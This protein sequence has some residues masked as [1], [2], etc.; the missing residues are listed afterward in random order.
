MSRSI[1]SM[2]GMFLGVAQKP[3]KVLDQI[4]FCGVSVS[5]VFER[6]HLFYGE[7]G[8]KSGAG[9]AVYHG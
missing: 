4:G 7:R 5:I 9:W 1:A 8:N 6:L 3:K 2:E